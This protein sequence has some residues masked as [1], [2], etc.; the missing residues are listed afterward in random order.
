M[1]F[2]NKLALYIQLKLNEVGAKLQRV[3]VFSEIF[4]LLGQLDH[5][6]V[7]LDDILEMSLIL[8]GTALLK[9]A[10]TIRFLRAVPE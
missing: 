6:L 3:V 4:E 5:L 8:H 10:D 7:A 2:A 9:W 1:D